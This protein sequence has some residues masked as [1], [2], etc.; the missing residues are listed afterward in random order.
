[1]RTFWRDLLAGLITAISLGILMYVLGVEGNA[2][3]G[4]LIFPSAAIGIFSARALI[5]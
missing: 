4:F 1:M 5:P 2:A 3:I